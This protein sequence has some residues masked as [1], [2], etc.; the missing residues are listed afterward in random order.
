MM[1]ENTLDT[2]RK[3]EQLT[4]LE[5]LQ[6]N[7]WEP[8]VLISGITLAF[9]FAFPSKI[10]EFC[11]YLNQELGIGY[12]FSLLLVFYLTSIVSVFKIFFVVHLGLRFI[13]TGLLG[14]SYAFPKGAVNENL[15]KAAQT[16]N[17]QKPSLMVLRLEKICSMTF[18]Y[19]ISLVI[20]FLVFT[21]YLGILVGLYTYFDLNFFVI[22]LIFMGTMLIFAS[23]MIVKS[24]FKIKTWYAESIVSSIA[25]IYQSNI[26]KW[27]TLFYG[28]FIFIL[29]TPIILSDVR[30][31][32]LFQSERGLNEF[33]EEWPAKN[34]HYL[35]Q[36]DP[37][38][39]LPRAFISSEEISDNYLRVGIARYES[40][41]K[42]IDDLNSN[43]QVSLDTLGW[44][45]IKNSGDLHR[46][47]LDDS[48]I[49]VKSWAK[50]RLAFSGQ[51][52]YQSGI[53]ISHLENGIHE[54]R[55]EKLLLI[56]SLMDNKPEI[57]LREDWSVFSFVKK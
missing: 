10:Y 14:L 51:K 20:T 8:E 26:G 34:H 35:D 55:I 12:T 21:I 5:N 33:E 11:I 27:F 46:V 49:Q 1:E 3:Q 24:K 38:K 54:I 52:V 28:V 32:S 43:F 31:F 25:A 7:S 30:D 6:R 53:D 48:L 39:R 29:A 17:Y 47:Y 18:A 15:F 45:E 57:R 36:H 22:Y 23:L 50:N 2:D 42:V 37:E 4:W 41:H 16:Y 9:L 13:W 19:P 56:Y 44:K 40:D